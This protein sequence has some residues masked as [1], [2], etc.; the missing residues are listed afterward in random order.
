MVGDRKE[1]EVSQALDVF[2]GTISASGAQKTIRI[3]NA[4]DLY[5]HEHSRKGV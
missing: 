3:E 2:E 4:F 5:C 1:T